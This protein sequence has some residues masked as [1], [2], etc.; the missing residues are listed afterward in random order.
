MRMDCLYITI[1]FYIIYTYIIIAIIIA[2]RSRDSLDIKT[3]R[4]CLKL[5]LS[6]VE[7]LLRIV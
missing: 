7:Y 6:Y 1:V 2:I 4:E 5:R 3:I